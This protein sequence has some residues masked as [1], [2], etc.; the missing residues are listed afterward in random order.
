MTGQARMLP[1]WPQ[2]NFFEKKKTTFPNQH[3]QNKTPA[4]TMPRSS[5]AARS[6]SG[7]CHS[8]SC[9]DDEDCSSH[10]GCGESSSD[11]P[12]TTHGTTSVQE[13]SH[14]SLNSIRNKMSKKESQ[15]VFR[16]KVVVFLVLIL[17]ATA[18]SFVVYYL[19]Y[20]PDIEHSRA[21]NCSL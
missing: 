17:A 3:I 6:V 21:E 7:S 2:K 5:K 20:S 18:V 4:S 13:D 19:C 1:V 10:D 16:L 15:D 11:D 9:S 12:T 14:D 8:K